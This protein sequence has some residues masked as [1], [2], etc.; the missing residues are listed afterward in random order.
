MNAQILRKICWT[1]AHAAK[2]S[3]SGGPVMVS[4]EG[5]GGV[6]I[7][8]QGSRPPSAERFGQALWKIGI[9]YKFG[10]L[11]PDYTGH[12]TFGPVHKQWEDYVILIAR[13][14]NRQN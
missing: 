7:L 6:R 13:H 8:T 5:E 12:S 2:W 11:R 4:D 10:E 9:D 14:R 1:V 3:V